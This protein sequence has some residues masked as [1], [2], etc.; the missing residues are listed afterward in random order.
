M[1]DVSTGEPAMT[2]FW[3]DTSTLSAVRAC[4]ERV[5]SAY[6]QKFIPS[7]K[8]KLETSGPVRPPR[9]A[10]MSDLRVARPERAKQAA[11]ISA[12]CAACACET[13]SH[14]GVPIGP[15]AED[16]GRHLWRVFGHRTR[17][18]VRSRLVERGTLVRH[19]NVKCRGTLRTAVQTSV[20]EPAWP[21]QAG[22]E[23]Q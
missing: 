11:N 20:S 22:A 14:L 7:L 9:P 8:Q 17:G 4:G 16:D 10:I 19:N 5:S 15:A 3:Q 13:H 21:G 2:D 12:A 23:A 6:L 18:E 1:L